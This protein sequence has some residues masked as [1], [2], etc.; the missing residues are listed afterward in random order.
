MIEING[1]SSEL[2][3]L[4]A[5][6]MEKQQNSS[7]SKALMKRLVEIFGKQIHGIGRRYNILEE[8]LDSS[9]SF[10]IGVHRNHCGSGAAVTD[11]PSVEVSQ[12]INKF[13]Q[14][15]WGTNC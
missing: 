3:E 8:K 2:S 14:E 12:L 13:M 4:D 7:S 9:K 5:S 6:V 10:T 11:G 1:I 15:Q